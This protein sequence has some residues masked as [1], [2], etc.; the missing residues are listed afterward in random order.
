M[1]QFYLAGS[2]LLSITCYTQPMAT[3]FQKAISRGISIETLD[4]KYKP[5]LSS[6]SSES[7]FA[8]KEK[9]FYNAY[10]SLLQDLNT[11]LKKII[12]IGGK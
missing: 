11:Y 9:E 5:A 7:V 10:F 4:E 1:M 8:G 2:L 6:D 12:S 3:T